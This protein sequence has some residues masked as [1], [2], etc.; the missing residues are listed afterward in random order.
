LSLTRY[1]TKDVGE[2]IVFGKEGWEKMDDLKGD[3]VELEKY[4]REKLTRV[5]FAS[6]SDAE[7][8]VSEYGKFYQIPNGQW[9]VIVNVN[10]VR[11]VCYN[12]PRPLAIRDAAVQLQQEFPST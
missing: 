4:V 8:Y 9:R 12:S 7:R 5:R 10:G 1:S 6:F 3:P 11:C 2:I